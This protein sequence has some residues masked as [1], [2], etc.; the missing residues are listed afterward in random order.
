MPRSTAS[1]SARTATHPR[2]RKKQAAICRLPGR[3]S[4]PIR[5]DLLVNN[6][7]ITALKR[8]KANW[9][10]NEPMRRAS[11]S[12]HHWIRPNNDSASG[13]PE[14]WPVD[15]F[16]AEMEDRPQLRRA[17]SPKDPSESEQCAMEPY[18]GGR[19]YSSSWQ[20]D[21]HRFVSCP[22][23]EDGDGK[24]RAALAAL[25]GF[26]CLPPGSQPATRPFPGSGA[27]STRTKTRAVAH[28]RGAR[29][30]RLR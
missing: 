30:S 28:S 6:F 4:G 5:P 12:C 10:E 11:K 9:F 13:G 15:S 24:D 1:S 3:V 17:A 16:L 23:A 18:Y 21:V 25:C 14:T 29:R 7:L 8:P 20:S 26:G 22:E 27:V 2:G 19:Y